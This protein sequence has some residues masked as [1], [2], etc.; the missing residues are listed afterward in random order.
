MQ[1]KLGRVMNNPPGTNTRPR[2]MY[3]R[4]VTIIGLALIGGIA[5]T[6]IIVRVNAMHSECTVGVTGTAAN[7]TYQG[8]NVAAWCDG[9]VSNNNGYYYK[10]TSP[11]TGTELCEGDINVSTWPTFH[12]I[13]RDTG[14]LDTVGNQLCMMQNN[15]QLIS[16]T[17]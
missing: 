10:L 11:P 1:E 17:P 8:D 5:L 9:L 14:L 13:V 4:V 2:D 16:P 3:V 12:Y 15:F 6:V 7:V